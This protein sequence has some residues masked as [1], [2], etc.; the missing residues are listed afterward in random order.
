MAEFYLER[1]TTETGEHLV[2]SSTCSSLPAKETMHYM[3]AYAQ[4]P[5]WEASIRYSKV[6][7]CEK[8]IPAWM[9]MR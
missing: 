4:A 8:C 9:K 3:G 1:Q 2:H 7:T 5:V 6:S